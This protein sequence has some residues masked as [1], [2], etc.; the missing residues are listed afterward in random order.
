MKKRFHYGWVICISCTVLMVCTMGFAVN[1]FSIY[2]PYIQKAHGFTSSQLS[3]VPTV[4]SLFSLI[5]LLTV[6]KYFQKTGLRAGVAGACLMTCTAFVLFSLAGGLAAYY[7][8]AA[9]LGLAYGYGGLVPAAL[10][11]NRW[12]ASRRG[13]ALG[14]CV[15]GSGI[16][17][18]VG[19]PVF[20]ALIE[21][22]S[23]RTAFLCEALF[24]AAVCVLIFLFVRNDPG[25]LKLAPYGELEIS[26]EEQTAKPPRRDLRRGEYA[27]MLF[28]LMCMGMTVIPG[29]SYYALHFTTCGFSGMAAAAAVS[30]FGLVLTG[31]K[32]LFGVLADRA[33]CRRATVLAFS[34]LLLGLGLCCSLQFLRSPVLLFSSVSLMGL[35]MPPSTVGL[36]LWASELSSQEHFPRTL[37]HFQTANILGAF[38]GSSIPGVLADFTGSYLPGY[39]LHTLFIAVTLTAVRTL[40]A[41]REREGKQAAAHESP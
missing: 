15:C 4:R 33:G 39:A 34:S 3:L 26:A 16:G 7:A 18:T 29:P 32:F 23:L 37:R 10:L 12:F 9:F 5:A 11:I 22:F 28:A 30:A 6:D 21:A 38:L 2:M 25:E 13:F 20:A 40:Y 41:R 19:P 14:I 36:P 31:S 27:F 35:G 24:I 17:A 1:A 8:G